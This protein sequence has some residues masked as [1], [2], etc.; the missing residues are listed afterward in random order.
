MTDH[1]RREDISALRQLWKTVFGDSDEFLDRFFALAFAPDRCLCLWE[2]GVLAGMVHWLPCEAPPHRFGYIYAVATHPDHRGKGIC[3]RLMERAHALLPA[4][5]Y[6][7][8]L[9]YPQEEGLREM[10]RKMGYETTTF[11]EE[12]ICSPGAAAVTL[13]PLSPEAYFGLRPQYL[14]EESVLQDEPFRSLLAADFR[15][16]RGPG[17]LLTARL[18]ENHLNCPEFLGDPS[19]LPGI[20]RTLGAPFARYRRPGSTLPFAMFCPLGQDIRPPAYFA[21]ALE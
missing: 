10:Y 11:L 13:E 4:Q 1:P 7:G 14:P 21:F 6:D 2:E 16:Y 9:L 12:G 8:A 19:V 5:G 3:R 15:F 20:L 17:C 18:E